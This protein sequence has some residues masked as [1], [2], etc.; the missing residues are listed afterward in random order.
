[1]GQNEFSLHE[2][3]NGPMDQMNGPMDP[4]EFKTCAAPHL[5]LRANLLAHLRPSQKSPRQHA[6]H[7]SLHGAL[8]ERLAA[9]STSAD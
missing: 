6:I 4:N 5:A 2:W 9:G 3:K 1:M 8:H 7:Q